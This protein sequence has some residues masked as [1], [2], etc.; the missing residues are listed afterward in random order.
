MRI[1]WSTS[2]LPMNR[3][4]PLTT[5]LVLSLGLPRSPPPR[6]TATAMVV[7]T[8]ATGAPN[9]TLRTATIAAMTV[10]SDGPSAG[11]TTEMSVSRRAARTARNARAIATA[12]S[13]VRSG[14]MIVGSSSP[15]RM[16]GPLS[17]CAGIA[18]AA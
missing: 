14:R 10:A 1:R 8:S 11:T 9:G 6:I 5:A 17:C 13:A 16:A 12:T 7:T 18:T 4:L 15:V 3:L 2:E